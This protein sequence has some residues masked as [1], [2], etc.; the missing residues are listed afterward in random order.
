MPIEAALAGSEFGGALAA[1]EVDA[2]GKADLLIGAPYASPS[3]R[4]G[5]GAVYLLPGRSPLAPVNLAAQPAALTVIGAKAGDDLGA[6]VALG[7]LTSDGKRDLVLGAPTATRAGQTSAGAAYVLAWRADLPPTLDLAAVTPELLL[8]GATS[9]DKLGAAVGA[10]DLNG[11]GRSDLLA[12]VPNGDAPGRPQ[13]GLLLGL[14]GQPTGPLVAQANVPDLTIYGA[15]AG[16]RTGITLAGADVT[17][18]GRLD[19]ILAAP[20]A[21]SFSGTDAGRIYVLAGPI[22]PPPPPPTRTPTTT[23]TRTPTGTPTA[24][25]T[26]TGTSTST[27]TPTGTPTATGTPTGTSTSTRTPTGTPTATGTPTG[28]STSTRTPILR[29]LPLLIKGQPQP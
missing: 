18:D 15:F 28:T 11:D 3:G 8:E 17:G 13:S 25:G 27:R 10:V 14:Q 12:G 24:T 22:G 9:Y 29:Y 23:S 20:R 5:A 19:L 21:D 4:N 2:D 7:D 6:A 1:A 26:P 16:D